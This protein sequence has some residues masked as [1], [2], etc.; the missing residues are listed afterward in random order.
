MMILQILRKTEANMDDILQT[1]LHK[2]EKILW[3]GKAESF[4]TLDR[5]HRSAYLKKLYITLA[6]TL[7]C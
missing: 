3:E 2:N 1:I 6:A 4:T 5:T 7:R